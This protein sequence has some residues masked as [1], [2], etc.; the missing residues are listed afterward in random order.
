MPDDYTYNA[1]DGE[2]INCTANINPN[3]TVLSLIGEDLLLKQNQFAERENS[4]I[5]VDFEN[6]IGCNPIVRIVYFELKKFLSSYN[7]VGCLANDTAT[8]QIFITEFKTVTVLGS[9]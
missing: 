9:Q 5:F 6:K 4:Q 2:T 8:G 1:L 3:T 7:N